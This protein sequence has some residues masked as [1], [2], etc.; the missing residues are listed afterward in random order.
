[1]QGTA[2]ARELDHLIQRM[3]DKDPITK[4][5][6]RRWLVFAATVEASCKAIKKQ[7]MDRLG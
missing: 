2:E 1:M 7:A 5:N 4:D 6:A 3:L